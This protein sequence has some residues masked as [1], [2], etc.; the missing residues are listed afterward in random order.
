[1]LRLQSP[2]RTCEQSIDVTV[3]VPA[4]ATSSNLFC[5]SPCAQATQAQL[6]EG[7]PRHG[8]GRPWGA[9]REGHAGSGRH[10]SLPGR[11]PAWAWP[12]LRP[13]H[14]SHASRVCSSRRAQPRP[15]PGFRPRASAQGGAGACVFARRLTARLRRSVRRGGLSRPRPHPLVRWRLAALS[16]RPLPAWP[17]LPRAPHRPT[18]PTL[19]RFAGCALA[20]LVRTVGG[21]DGGCVSHRA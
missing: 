10:A 8:A 18:A 5:R 3:T 20:W 11:P 4:S 12:C 21:R 19:L 15:C 13:A 16:G 2:R 6:V 9:G 14:R 1:M 7:R 17:S